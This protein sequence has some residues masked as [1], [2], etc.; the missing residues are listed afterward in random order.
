MPVISKIISSIDTK[1]RAS[2][3]FSAGDT[4]R[5]IQKVKEGDKV[6]L[7]AFEGLVIARRRGKEAGATF[8]L[9]KVSD[10]IGVE[11]IFP[12]YS[13]AIE[14]IETVSRSRTRRAK[15]YYVRTKALKEIQ[16]KLRR[17]R[18]EERVNKL[19]SRPAEAIEAVGLSE[20]KESAP[21]IKKVPEVP[22][23]PKKKGLFKRLLRR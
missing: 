10:G 12:L 13:S 16:K 3:K 20:K 18:I 6:R 22:E 7:Q 4:V 11:R 19:V 5:V 1:E 2:L 9:R 17:T 14:K 21:E 15:L 23:K 8:T